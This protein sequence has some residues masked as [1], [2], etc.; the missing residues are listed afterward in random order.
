MEV[1]SPQIPKLNLSKRINCAIVLRGVKSLGL[2]LKFTTIQSRIRNLRKCLLKVLK[3]HVI[4][5]IF[6][7]GEDKNEWDDVISRRLYTQR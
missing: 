7:R 4:Y 2:G 1:M 3:I 5:C 6:I